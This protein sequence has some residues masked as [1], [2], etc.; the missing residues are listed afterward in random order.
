MAIDACKQQY[1]YAQQCQRVATA[2][3]SD[4]VKAAS[5]RNAKGARRRSGMGVTV[6]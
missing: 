5:S 3:A 2:L 1:P 4:A 6:G